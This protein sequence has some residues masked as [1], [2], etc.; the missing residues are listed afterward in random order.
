MTSIDY[1]FEAWANEWYT[2]HKR[3]ISAT[4]AES[5]GYTLRLLDGNFG[6]WPLVSIKAM[7]IEDYLFALQEQGY[8]DSQVTKCR[9]M[10]YQIMQKAVANDLIGKNPVQYA[11]KLRHRGPKR[12]KDAFN[13]EEIAQLDRLLPLDKMGL[14]IRLMLATGI[15]TQELL[16][17]EP[18]H[19]EPDGS[20]LHIVQAVKVARGKPYVGPPKS[21]AS[22]R[23]VPV[24]Q[25]A[26]SYAIQLRGSA[27]GQ[28]YV[29]QA[30]DN[31]QPYDPSHFR[32]KF[33]G[34]LQAAGVRTLTPHCCRHTYISQ[35]QAVGVDI[36]TIQ[37]IVGHTDPDMTRHYLHVQ[38]GVIEDAVAKYN[39]LLA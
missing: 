7:D 23:D 38:S 10:L 28:K 18:E 30:S 15:R 20:M 9:G 22:L 26:R 4:T 39:E 32:R 2:R 33:V 11:E 17:L 6:R 34:Y 27:D 14:S 1:T 13:M 3:R 29:W 12:Q 31:Q 25:N 21:A 35:M 16:A 5:Y 8:S 37:A 24:P 19:I 36:S